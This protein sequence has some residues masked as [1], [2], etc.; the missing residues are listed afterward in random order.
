MVAHRSDYGRADQFKTLCGVGDANE[1][2]TPSAILMQ[3]GDELRDGHS[4]KTMIS[5]S[6]Q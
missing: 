2:F 3:F 1:H 4:E 6:G 5:N